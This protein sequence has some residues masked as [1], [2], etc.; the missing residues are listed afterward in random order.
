MFLRRLQA[1]FSIISLC[2][3][4]ILYGIGAVYFDLW[5]HS[6]VV[7]ARNAYEAWSTAIRDEAITEKSLDMEFWETGDYTGPTVTVHKSI[8]GAKDEYILVV[9]GLNRLLS[10]CPEFGCLAWL[11]NRAG[12]VA[13]VWSIDPELVWG[14]LKIVQGFARARNTFPVGAHLYEDGSLLLSYQG[15][16]T[17][18]YGVGII[19]LDRDSNLLWRRE[20]LSHHW[21]TLDEAGR[22]Y[23]PVFTEVNQPRTLSGT[24]LQIGC[25]GGKMYVDDVAVLDADGNEIERISILDRFLTSN[26]AGVIFQHKYS[27]RDLPLLYDECDPI[28]LNDVQ[29]LLKDE[30]RDSEILSGGDLL[31]SLRNT[32]SVAV[33][34]G[35]T[36]AVKWIETGRTLLQHSPRYIGG[37]RILVFDNL[38]G[39]AERGGSRVISINMRNNHSSIVFPK[40]SSLDT[41]FL[42]ATAGYIDLSSDRDRALVSLTR[43]GKTIEIDINS[44]EVL[45]EFVNTH[46]IT[47]VTGKN[48]AGEHT[49]GRFSTLTVAYVET[50]RFPMN[51]G[52]L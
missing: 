40:E 47:D 2:F 37:G 38:G 48:D 21:F 44:G 49:Y 22:I 27:D 31:I 23:V 13:H 9:G 34:D 5:P 17:Y 14:D 30:A 51:G 29:V 42:S 19:K 24:N 8:K 52:A 50:P 45:W 3:L 25:S 16:N 11:M 7:A 26:Y 1:L 15:R 4:S 36:R 18:P 32:N 6:T 10:H 35:K 39:Q 33:L 20:N 41:D 28:H 43:Q 46:D 12:E